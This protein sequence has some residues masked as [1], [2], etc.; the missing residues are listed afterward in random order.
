M[1]R[2]WVCCF[3]TLLLAP[4]AAEAASS[5]K[6]IVADLSASRI[7]L[8]SGF[9]GTN[10]LLFGARND[11]GDIIVTVRG[12][13]QTYIVRKKSRVFGVWVNKEQ[14]VFKNIPGYY[15][16]ASSKKLG[17]IRKNYYFKP[18]QIGLKNLPASPPPSTD[19]AKYREF[20][21]ALVQHQ[22][23]RGLFPAETGKISFLE[24]TLFKTFI[25]FPDTIIRGDYTAEIYLF[26]DGQLSGMETAPIRVIKTG[27]DAL[28]SDLAHHYSALYGLLAIAVAVAAGWGASALF[29][30]FYNV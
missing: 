17:E 26:N 12:P 21:E 22:I 4:L 7:E 27:F 24:E 10:L 16:L 3:L 15:A 14:M 6:P 25:P 18:L 9:T 13:E 30:R 28:V 19:R 1:M 20:Y 29:E 2:R 5:G 23:R 8:N 11:S